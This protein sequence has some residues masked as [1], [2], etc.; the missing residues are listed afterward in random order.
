MTKNNDGRKHWRFGRIYEKEQAQLWN[1]LL[2]AWE[3]FGTTVLAKT[4][5][6]KKLQNLVTYGTVYFWH[7][8]VDYIPNTCV[9]A[10]KSSL[11]YSSQLRP[12]LSFLQKPLLSVAVICVRAI[13]LPEGG[14][15]FA[16]K[17]LASCSNFYETVEKK[18]GPYDATT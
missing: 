16:Q 5:A 12:I 18:L 7:N 4:V 10:I 1:F 11:E 2:N 3:N 14:K 13:F 8:P 9:T 6:S 15:P 17:I